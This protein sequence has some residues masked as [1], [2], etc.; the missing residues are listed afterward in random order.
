M[1][2]HTLTIM[3]SRKVKAMHMIISE[4]VQPIVHATCVISFSR[5]VPFRTSRFMKCI[6][7]EDGILSESVMIVRLAVLLN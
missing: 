4:S 1:H 3:S 6:P 2:M 7:L 5:L